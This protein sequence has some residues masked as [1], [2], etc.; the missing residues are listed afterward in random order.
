MVPTEKNAADWL[1]KS[2]KFQAFPPCLKSLEEEEV[3]AFYAG[4]VYHVLQ[5]YRA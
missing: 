1:S 5:L 3:F 4:S 2:N